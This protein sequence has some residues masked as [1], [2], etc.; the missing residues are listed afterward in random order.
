M[1]PEARILWGVQVS[2][3][4]MSMIRALVIVTGVKSDQIYARKDVKAE[5]F[6]IQIVQ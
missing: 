6:G 3:E 1:N 4:L 5:K 2:P